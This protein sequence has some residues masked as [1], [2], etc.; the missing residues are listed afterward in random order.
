MIVYPT[1]GSETENQIVW[2][3]VQLDAET[4]WYRGNGAIDI[5]PDDQFQ[6][7]RYP[8]R[9]ILVY[10]NESIN[11]AWHG[12]LNDSPI[13]VTRDQWIVGE[14]LVPET[15]VSGMFVRPRHDSDVASVIAIAGTDETGLR[16]MTQHALFVPFTR[17]PDFV[18]WSLDGSAPAQLRPAVAGYFGFDWSL[19]Y[20]ET[21]WAPQSADAAAR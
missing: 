21:A 10:G 13:R 3:K 17:Y 7:A 11:R 2:Q 20:G 19:K 6:L 12:L 16:M 15:H 1:G 9:T 5:V 8:D 18:A 14:R 4:W